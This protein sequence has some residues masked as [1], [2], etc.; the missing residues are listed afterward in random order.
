MIRVTPGI[1]I[2]ESEVE[3][4]FLRASGP[5][6][7]NVNKVE[8][9]GQ[10]R[11]DLHRSQSLPADVYARLVRLAGKR[12]TQDGVLVITARRHRTQHL[13]RKDAMEK[14]VALIRQ[15]AVPPVPRRKTRPTGASR[16]RRLKSK[17][18]R[19]ATKRLRGK[20][21]SED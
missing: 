3:E 13:N 9:A 2:D 4:T 19:G 21:P 17:Q 18:H 7:Q 6:G 10:L 12:V 5:G 1:V 14:L 16:Q 11:F 15:A 20:P 8:T